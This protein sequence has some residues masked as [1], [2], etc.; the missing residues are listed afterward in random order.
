METDSAQSKFQH[1]GRARKHFAEFNELVH[2]HEGPGVWQTT[3]RR[4]PRTGE[5]FY[6]LYMDR[7]RLIEVQPIIADSATNIAAALDHAAAAIARAN[8]HGRSRML[9]FPWALN[10]ERFEKALAKFEPAIGGEMARVIAAVRAKHRHEIHHVE[11]AKQISNTGK[12][13]EL[14]FAAG[15]AHGVALY[16]PV[17]SS[18]FSKFQPTLLRA[19]TR[20]NFIAGQNVCLPCQRASLLALMLADST[21]DYPSR[22]TRSFRARSASLMG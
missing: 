21:R 17:E 15:A 12:H 18:K 6:R 11:A 3:E 14:M 20:S 2:P 13:W 8:G 19:P 9:H 16:M 7:R 1:S 5:F 10:D 4:H 22:Q